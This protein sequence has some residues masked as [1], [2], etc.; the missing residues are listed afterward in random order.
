MNKITRLDYL[1]PNLMWDVF[2]DTFECKSLCLVSYLDSVCCFWIFDVIFEKNINHIW[3]VKPIVLSKLLFY[4]YYCSDK[5]QSIHL[6]ILH[7]YDIS[8]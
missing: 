8:K 2:I 6:L 3:S 1:G 4:C 5:L 7:R